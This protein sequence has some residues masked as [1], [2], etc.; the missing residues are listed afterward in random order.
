MRIILFVILMAVG[1]SGFGFVGEARAEKTADEFL[2][3]YDKYK[4][5]GDEQ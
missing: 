3:D 1:L 4:A 2:D 5:K